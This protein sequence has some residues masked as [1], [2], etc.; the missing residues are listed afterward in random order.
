VSFVT[1]SALFCCLCKLVTSASLSWSL[2]SEEVAEDETKIRVQSPST[3]LASKKKN[4]PE[5]ATDEAPLAE[6]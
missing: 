5:E 4:P 2:I 1:C 3:S 6:A